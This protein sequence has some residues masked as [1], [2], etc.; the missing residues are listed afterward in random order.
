M[1]RPF[2]LRKPTI[3]L[4]LL[5]LIAAAA[6]TWARAEGGVTL[7]PEVLE[8]PDPVA[9]SAGWVMR[10]GDDPAWADPALDDG[11]WESVADTSLTNAH[12]PIH[13]WDGMAWFRLHVT[14]DPAL[15]NRPLALELRQ[16]GASEVYVDGVLVRRFGTIG[17]VGTRDSELNPHGDPAAL[18]FSGGPDH[19]IAVRY[20]CKSAPYVDRGL[21]RLRSVRE[22]GYGFTARLGAADRA[23]RGASW[24][25]AL[26]SGVHFGIGT[27]VLGMAACHFVLYRVRRQDLANLF[28]A[29]FGGF[30][31]LVVF[32]TFVQLNGHFGVKGTAVTSIV[33]FAAFSLSSIA[34]LAMLEAMIGEYS[35]GWFWSLVATAVVLGAVPLVLPVTTGLSLFLRMLLSLVV[36]ARMIVGVRSARRKG[37]RAWRWLTWSVTGWLLLQVPL[38][39]PALFEPIPLLGGVVRGL[40]LVLMVALPSVYLIR[41]LAAKTDKAEARLADLKALYGEQSATK[42]G[43]SRAA[44]ARGEGEGPTD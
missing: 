32:A 34:F 28:Y 36:L 11:D 27:F 16:G 12:F 4:P 5:L 24:E 21:D 9:L 29:W 30:F 41:T 22:L 23:A 35:A 31:S 40:G 1:R 13:A 25:A 20:S 2:F 39:A 18:V 19:V 17:A 33:A 8:G 10:L 6:P 26:A 7:G 14:V 37:R 15:M 42:M 43:Q 44:L 3:S 38:L